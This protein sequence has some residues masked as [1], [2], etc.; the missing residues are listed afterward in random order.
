MMKLIVVGTPLPFQPF[1]CVSYGLLLTRYGVLSRQFVYD[2][3]ITIVRTPYTKPT[4]PV[5]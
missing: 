2:T 1:K 3:L 4:T 5:P